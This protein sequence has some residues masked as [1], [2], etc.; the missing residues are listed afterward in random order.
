MTFK[1][2]QTYAQ[3]NILLIVATCIM[4]L[5][6]V[7]NGN[8]FAEMTVLIRTINKQSKKRSQLLDLNF[9]VMDKIA[10]PGDLSDEII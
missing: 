4:I 1:G 10:L 7:V 6:Y 5:S 8:L 2:N 9:R 3:S